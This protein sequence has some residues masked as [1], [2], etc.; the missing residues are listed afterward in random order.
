[1]SDDTLIHEVWEDFGDSGESLPSL[2]LAGPRG[3]DA[4]RSLSPRAKL[5]TTIESC[6]HFDAMTAYHKFWGWG[7]YT[8]DQPW[9]CEPY[10]EEWIAEQRAS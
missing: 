6:C 3:N 8:T 2:I 9:D 4:R 5:V 7:K 10:P 1:M